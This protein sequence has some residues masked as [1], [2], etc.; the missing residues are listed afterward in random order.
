M[1][2]NIPMRDGFVHID[3]AV[4][5]LREAGLHNTA[6]GLSDL[7]SA[8]ET[9]KGRYYSA[10]EAVQAVAEAYR[11]AAQMIL[12]RLGTVESRLVGGLEPDATVE[13]LIQLVNEGK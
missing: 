7:R 6:D 2:L 13:M 5:A 11:S 8:E 10:D 3:D 9:L 4:Q 12:G 1:E